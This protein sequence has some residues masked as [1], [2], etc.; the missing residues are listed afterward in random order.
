MQISVKLTEE[1][2]KELRTRYA[3]LLS[4]GSRDIFEA[5]EPLTYKTPEGDSLLHIA[6]MRGD[7]DTVAMLLN[8]GIDPNLPG[9]MGNTPLHYAC[10]KHN[11]S[12]SALLISHGARKDIK[13]EFGLFPGCY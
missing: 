13:N 4:Y 2:I 1:Q 12:L 11:E 3:D 8:A 5:I 10:D 6:A 7:V 9:D